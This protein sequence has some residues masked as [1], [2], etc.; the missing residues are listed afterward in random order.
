MRILYDGL[1]RPSPRKVI[2]RFDGLGRPSYMGGAKGL[3]ALQ[4]VNA[5]GRRFDHNPLPAGSACGGFTT[6]QTASNRYFRVKRLTRTP[7]SSPPPATGPIRLTRRVA[8]I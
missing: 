7:G 4:K 6:P 3:G 5:G 8:V 1:P 2:V